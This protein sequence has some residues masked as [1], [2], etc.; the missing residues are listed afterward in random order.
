VHA[1]LVAAAAVLVGLACV[2]SRHQRRRQDRAFGELQLAAAAAAVHDHVQLLIAAAAVS[3]WALL[4][5]KT[6]LIPHSTQHRAY[7]RP[8]PFLPPLPL[9]PA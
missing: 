8:S 1:L 9:P 7:L 3:C 6:P 4:V 5:R 2:C